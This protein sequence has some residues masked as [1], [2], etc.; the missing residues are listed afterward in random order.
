MSRK[1]IIGDVHGCLEE[2]NLLL[3]KVHYVSGD[4]TLVFLGDFMD[5][6]PDPVGVVRRVRELGALAVLGNHED[7]HLGWRKHVER[8]KARGKSSTFKGDPKS[9]TQNQNLSEEDIAWMRNLPICL[10]IGDN[11]VAVHGGFEPGLS[12]GKQQRDH[13][14][15][16]RW[17]D[18]E[19]LHVSL[20]GRATL[21]QP[22]GTYYWAE[23]WDGPFNVVYGHV[24]HSLEYPRIDTLDGFE[25]WGLDTGCCFGGRLSALILD[26]TKPEL[27][28]IV[29]VK[30]IGTYAQLRTQ[31]E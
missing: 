5:R 24:V 25:C 31:R 22:G 3:G 27:R 28:E 10:D 11:W 26:S 30:A 20:A 6:G 9:L 14:I 18:E 7:K 1:I 17:V 2:L 13:V 19:G 21:D 8:N 23:K 4:D 12:L 29:Q 16:L 15:R